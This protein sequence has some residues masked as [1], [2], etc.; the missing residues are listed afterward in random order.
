[1][2]TFPVSHWSTEEVSGGGYLFDTYTPP[3]VAYSFR[4]LK[5]SAVNC[6]RL[7][8]SSDNSETDVLLEDS[9]QITMS[10]SVS[11]GGTLG[12]WIGSN[13]AF[14]RTW[15]DQSGNGYDA[16]QTNNSWQPYL[17]RSGVFTYLPSTSTIAADSINGSKILTA[18]INPFPST[19]N[20]KLDVFMVEYLYQAPSGIPGTALGCIAPRTYSG[21]RRLVQTPGEEDYYAYPQTVV[22]LFGGNIQYT[23]Q[24]IANRVTSMYY[25]TV[26][27]A[28]KVRQNGTL[29]TE[30]SIANAGL[31]IQSDSA[32]VVCGS[33]SSAGYLTGGY[34]GCKGY[35]AES[36][37]YLSDEST[38]RIAIENELRA[39]YN[40]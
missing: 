26:G 38:N 21:D 36:F 13:D 2:S 33:N 29:L 11:T 5:S 18:I 25:N 40:L 20:V 15:Y 3:V 27:G 35:L 19:G 1:M 17:I 24:L 4:K 12:T 10:S 37:W 14:I 7:R 34:S 39:Y 31:N 22:R 23:T 30:S 28:I 8:R 9:G 32:I 6:C 16:I